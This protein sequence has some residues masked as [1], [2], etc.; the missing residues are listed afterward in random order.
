MQGYWRSPW[1]AEDAGPSRQAAPHGTPGPGIGPGD[2]L[3][4]THRPVVAATM[5]VQRE[6]GQLYL[7]AHTPGPVGSA[8]VERIDPI[9]LD[10]L[11]RT[12]DLPGGPVWPGGL[13]A[14][15]DGS[16]HS[17]F[18]RWCHRLSPD[19]EVLA[20][21]ALPRDRSYNSFVV[22][23]SGH[24]V[25]KDFGKDTEE[26][27][28]LVV[29][30]PVT[31]EI[32]ASLLLPERSIARLS[33]DGD[34]VYVVGDTHLWRVRWD[35][36]GLRLDGD[37]RPAYRRWPGQGY[38]WD[39]VIAGG[40]AWFLD[41]GEGTERYA[42]TFVGHGIA[43]VP[44]HLVRAPLDGDEPQ[45]VEVCG[46]PGGIVANPPAIDVE[47]GVAVAYDSGNAEMVAF[48]FGGGPLVSEPLWRRR[49]AHA[50]HLVVF[51]D[52]GELVVG[53]HDGARVADQ[54]VVLDIESGEERAR[55]DTGSPLQSVLFPCVGWDRDVYLCTF[56]TVSRVQVVR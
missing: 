36:S 54:V 40:S 2:R 31:L 45:L 47:R 43:E 30:D 55:A 16:L 20:S 48:R 8:W 27:A 50:G 53:D 19:L 13:A 42:G 12:P 25:T 51:P 37:F 4:V 14:H 24:L 6:P 46:R 33:A 3:E 15:A 56:S 9:T 17:V 18:G 11:A 52:T 21:R 7:L 28:E 10:P 32:V 1:P 49:L 44:L 39:A 22:V 23:P 34:D 26:P 41:D 38:G 35:G 29:L 5:L